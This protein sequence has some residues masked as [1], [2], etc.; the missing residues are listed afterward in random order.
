MHCFVYINTTSG[1]PQ[2]HIPVCNYWTLI[3]ETTM[4]R[5][6]KNKTLLLLLLHQRMVK[7]PAFT[8]LHITSW[9]L[10][11]LSP[12][13]S[14]LFGLFWLVSIYLTDELMNKNDTE[15]L[16][17]FVATLR[18]S[19]DGCSVKAPSLSYYGGRFIFAVRIFASR[20]VRI[21]A[22]RLV[23]WNDGVLGLFCAHWLG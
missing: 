21:F 9:M 23:K 7:R 6:T 20:L 13:A 8:F 2:M 4:D 1:L 19:F 22:S 10:M 5:I 11:F 17:I 14:Y 16:V 12:R 3:G 18:L 15:K